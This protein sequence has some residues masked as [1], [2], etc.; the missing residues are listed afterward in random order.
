MNTER[1][2]V[3][4]LASVRHLSFPPSLTFSWKLSQVSEA[5]GYD[6]AGRQSLSHTS[7]KEPTY[8]HEPVLGYA[9]IVTGLYNLCAVF[10]NNITPSVVIYGQR[11]DESVK[12]AP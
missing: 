1:L 7:C 11:K 10:V 9:I 2:Y 8:L 4:V 12:I 6:I 5:L 3:P